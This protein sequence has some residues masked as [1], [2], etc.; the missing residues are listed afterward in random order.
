MKVADTQ[1]SISAAKSTP[2]FFK[3]RKEENKLPAFES[4]P[5]FFKQK[6]N[7]LSIVQAKLTIG[8]PND[9]FEQEAESMADKIMLSAQDTTVQ[10]TCAHCKEEETVQRKYYSPFIQKRGLAPGTEAT[11]TVSN[12][13]TASQGKGNSLSSSTKAF[14]EERFEADFSGVRLHTDEKAVQLTKE[15]NAQAFT[16]GN[17]IYFNEGKYSPETS[18][19]KHLLAHELTHTIQQNHSVQRKPSIQKQEATE[20]QMPTGPVPGNDA[21]MSPEGELVVNEEA[22]QRRNEYGQQLHE[23][24]LAPLFGERPDAIRFTNRLRSLAADQANLLVFDDLFWT[25]IRTVFRGRS[26]WSVFTILYFNNHLQEPHL[27]LSY[28][29]SSHDARLLA[30]MLSIV[31]LASPGDRYFQFLRE[32]V[33]IE[34]ASDPLLPE[35][36]RLIDH[37][38]DADISQRLSGSYHEA[39]YEPTAAGPYAIRTFGGNVS[40]N[41]Y[42]SGSQFRVIVRLHFVDGSDATHCG[43]ADS[44]TC[45]PFYFLGENAAVQTRWTNAMTNAWNNKFTLFN[46]GASYQMVFV[47]LFMTERDPNAVNIR[48]IADRSLR[49]DPTLEPGRSEQSCWFLNVGDGTVA[50]EFGHILGASDEYNLPGS[51]QEVTDAGFTLSPED[52]RLSTMEGI[53]GTPSPRP[54][55]GTEYATNSLMGHHYASTE[56]YVRHLTRLLRLLNAGLPPGTPPFQIRRN[57]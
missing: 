52:M 3:K 4:T 5:P 10:R 9:P 19:G 42:F 57:S 24:V 8:L 33:G 32:V 34:F 13:I 7:N 28:A 49:C 6:T 51:N 36:L 31:I 48:V 56:V 40:A 18:E 54:T 26:L 2:L 50:H 14:M 47:P 41:S 1:A 35:L 55:V 12:Q 15:L 46:S 37:R 53:H 43:D 17:D 20:P 25:R 16:T 39:H 45:A 11:E 23:A 21:I 38:T 29:V 27:R 30:D 22:Q 44:L